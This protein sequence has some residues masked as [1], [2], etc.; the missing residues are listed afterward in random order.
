MNDAE[1]KV[2][3]LKKVTLSFEAGTTKSEM[4]LTSGPQFYDLVVGIGAEGFTPFEYALLDKKVGD[5]I[6]LEVYT[7]GM[8]ET[9]GHIDIPL[10]QS[11]RELDFFFL[12][13]TLDQI[14]TVD[15]SGLVRA[16]AGAVRD[17]GGDCC[18]H[19]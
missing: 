3:G 8:K 18:G 1:Q 11:A 10:P 2:T 16:M 17:C 14:D 6:Q 13:I 4:D 9:F 15:Q 7:R 5:I 12:N 19:H